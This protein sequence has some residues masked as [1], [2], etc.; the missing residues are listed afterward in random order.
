MENKTSLTLINKEGEEVIYRKDNL[1]MGDVLKTLEFQERMEEEKLPL[2]KQL[3][4]LI[5]FNIELF[6]NK[7]ITRESILS[8]IPN[9]DSWTALNQPIAD[10]L[11]IDSETEVQGKKS[12]QEK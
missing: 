10:I 5:K 3:E 4:E 1:T 12:Q 7:K 9:V 11:G 2:S 8:G 6:N